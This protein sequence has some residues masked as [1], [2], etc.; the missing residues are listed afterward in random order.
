MCIK[1]LKESPLLWIPVSNYLNNSPLKMNYKTEY[2]MFIS[3]E[4]NILISM[5]GI[6]IFSQFYGID[7]ENDNAIS[8]SKVFCK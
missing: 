5:N 8:T 7:I 4:N 1:M 6:A 2:H 3:N